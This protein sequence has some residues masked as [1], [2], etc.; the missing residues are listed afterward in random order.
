MRLII[1]GCEY[2]GTT[3]LMNAISGWAKRVMGEDIGLH[4]HWKL[5]H[6]SHPP[7]LTDEEQQQFLALSP[8]IKEMFQRYHMEYHLQPSFYERPHHNLVG[9]HIDEAVYA[10]LYYGYGGKGQYAD[11]EVMAR[12]VEERMMRVAPETV[13]VLVRAS[14][15][16][17]AS[18][19]GRSPHQ[20]AVLQHKAIEYVLRRFD[21]E[22]QRSL[23]RNKLSIDTNSASVDDSLSEFVA[24]VEPFLTDGDRTRVLVHS[25]RQ[26]GEWL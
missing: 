17:I 15:E 22:H 14:S 9:M 23:I 18:R 4:D 21:E 10:P 6:V 25:A 26:R 20:N 16:V 7:G 8:N 19:M 3:T 5:P 13:H 2:S 24:K 1:S 11:R 12:H